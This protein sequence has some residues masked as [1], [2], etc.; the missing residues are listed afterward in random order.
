[1]DDYL[2]LSSWQHIGRVILHVHTVRS[3]IQISELVTYLIAKTISRRTLHHCIPKM[4]GLDMLY[5]LVVWNM[6]YFSIQL[7]ISPSQLT[8]KFFRG[9]GIPP[10]S[11][12]AM[13]K[14]QISQ[15]LQGLFLQDTGCALVWR[16]LWPPIWPLRSRKKVTNGRCRWG[17]GWV[18][19]N[20]FINRKGDDTWNHREK[21]DSREGNPEW[22]HQNAWNK[23]S[24]HGETWEAKDAN[25]KLHCDS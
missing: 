13:F 9:I 20:E 21:H 16:H 22:G 12:I 1:M 5:W 24:K 19:E 2:P 23:W 8:F 14:I 6:F 4:V 11:I 15:G 17:E 10:T 3:H 25:H 7:G 18:K